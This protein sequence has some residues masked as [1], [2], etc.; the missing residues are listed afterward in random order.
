MALIY[1]SECGK[2]YSDKAVACPNCGNPTNPVAAPAQPQYNAQPQYTAQPQYNA[3][4][5]YAAPAPQIADVLSSKEQ[6]S[7]II[8]AVIAGLQVIA[9]LLGAWLVLIV[10]VVNGIVAYSSFQKAKK[11]KRPYPGMVAEYEKQQTSLI[12]TLVYNLIFGG[13]IG[14]AGSIYDLVTRN[15]VLNNR[16]AFEAI[17]AENARKDEEEA[18]AN[19]KVRLTVEYACAGGAA[20]AI[21]CTLDGLA[22]KHLV[23]SAAP[24]SIYVAPGVH[25]LTVKYNFKDYRFQVVMEGNK[26]VSLY[27]SISDVK[28]NGIR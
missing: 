14:V 11:V 16:A 28:L 19:G 27:G 13:I 18:A 4:P 2:Q 17:A 21:A 22:E 26:T 6:T 20:T 15:Y 9:G 7:G 23:S 1:C 10:A 8:W 12:V 24:A 3:Q 25:V 5:Q